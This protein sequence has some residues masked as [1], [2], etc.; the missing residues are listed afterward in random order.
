MF[1]ETI[2]NPNLNVFDIPAWSEAAHALGLPLVVDNTVRD[3]DP[4]WP[5]PRRGHRRPLAD[6]VHRRADD[7][8]RR[9]GRRWPLRLDGPRRPLPRPDPA[10]PRATTAWSGPTPSARRPTS[11]G[12]GQCSCATPAPPCRPSTPGC[13][14]RGVE[15][16]PPA[17]RAAPRRT[18]LPSP[19]T[20]RVWAAWPGSTTR[21]SRARPPTR[22]PSACCTAAT[23][24]SS[25]SASRAVAR[26]ASGSS[27]RSA[28]SATWPTSA[29]QSHSPSTTPRPRTPRSSTTEE[30]EAA[31]VSARTSSASRL[32]IEHVD[33]LVEDP[34][35]GPSWKAAHARHGLMTSVVSAEP[36]LVGRVAT[37]RV[38][39]FT[40]DDPL[41]LA[42]GAT[43]GPVEVAHETYG[44]LNA[45]RSN[46]VFVCHALTGD[47]HA[48]GHHGDPSRSGWWDTLIEPGKPLDT[49]RLFVICANLLGGCQGTTGPASLDPRSWA[50]AAGLRFP[51]P[52]VS[53]LVTVHRALLRRPRPGRLPAAIGGSLGGMQVLQWAL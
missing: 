7:T 26:R 8:H 15:T 46:A 41:V 24:G 48:A 3:A 16:L 39:L 37:R 19:G 14:C 36:G 51:L 18:R 21:A 45:A 52:Q 9:R 50:A 5:R 49:G 34:R 38:V 30:L 40:E 17:D 2:G 29:T 20:S 32:G 27:S 23:A 28:C 12:C 4:C 13:S 6:E 53:D 43:L 10:R 11:A 44:E 35:A 1:G 22:R 31:G 47:A 42:S 33:D 25:P